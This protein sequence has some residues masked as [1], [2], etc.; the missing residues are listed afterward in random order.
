MY[1]SIKGTVDDVLE[2]SVIVD[3]FGVGYQLYVSHPKANFKNQKVFFYTYL[4]I[5]EDGQYLI[6]FPTLEEKQIFLLLIKVKGIGPKSAIQALS[7]TNPYDFKEAIATNNINFLKKLPGIGP[8]SA[9]Q[10]ILDL[11]GEF[12]NSQTENKQYVEAK[13]ALKQLG[14]KVSDINKVFED[15][16]VPNA[17][18][19]DL[20]SLAI[21]KLGKKYE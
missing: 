6:G 8:K 12:K 2:N 9:Y 17:S 14:F 21:S 13:E 3:V 11:R 19:N 18:L 10:I 4:V 20:L 5:K 7:G 1:Y 16:N 15:I